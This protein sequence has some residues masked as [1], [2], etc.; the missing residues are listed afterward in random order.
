LGN[1][2]AGT[3]Y[4][5]PGVDTHA[6]SSGSDPWATWNIGYHIGGS[7]LN[8]LAYSYELFYDFTPAGSGTAL[9][10]SLP[11]LLALMPEDSRNLGDNW[12]FVSDF[13]PTAVGT[14]SF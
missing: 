4:A 11:L 2:G 8:R 5:A 7:F 3:F 14:Y 9:G 1:D 13:D 6:P 12:L 10:G